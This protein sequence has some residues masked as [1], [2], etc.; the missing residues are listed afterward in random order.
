LVYSPREPQRGNGI[1]L[2]LGAQAS[3][4]AAIR[5]NGPALYRLALSARVT[6]LLGFCNYDLPPGSAI[7]GNQK[8]LRKNG[9]DLGEF[10]EAPEALNTMRKIFE[11]RFDRAA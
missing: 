10:L 2:S 4:P 8:F 7:F 9:V 5:E 11:R 3:S 6:S 1:E